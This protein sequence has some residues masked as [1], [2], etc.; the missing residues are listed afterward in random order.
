MKECGG[1][2]FAKRGSPAPLPKNSLT[3]KQQNKFVSL[4]WKISVD[5]RVQN[6][7]DDVLD[8]PKNKRI[9]VHPTPTGRGVPWCSRK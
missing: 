7:G 1:T 4:Q 2:F 5:K 9:S 3:K 8:I 6:L